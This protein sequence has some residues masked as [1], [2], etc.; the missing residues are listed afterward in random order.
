MGLL[1][2][3]GWGGPVNR[4]GMG[5]MSPVLSTLQDL[6]PQMVHFP[7]ALALVA[8]IFLL[9]ALFI[10]KYARSLAFSGWLL[11]ALAAAGAWAA[12]ST[13]EAA[14]HAAGAAG[15]AKALLKQHENQAELAAMILSVLAGLLALVLV[16]PR[17]I[18]RWNR[19]LWTRIA[20]AAILL[21]VL[22]GD[23]LVGLAAH[24]GGRLVHE[25]GVT[26]ARAAPAT[27]RR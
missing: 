21:L 13:G 1:S 11:L 6:H 9:L 14:E 22:A 4:K 18:A 8:P 26:A 12:V 17:V 7:I 2:R 5:V 3:V 25:F 24:K 19:P 15:T 20:L 10:P 16:V 23:V 27:V